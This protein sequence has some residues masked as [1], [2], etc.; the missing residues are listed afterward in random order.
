MIKNFIEPCL[1]IDF[2]AGDQGSNETKRFLKAT[3]AR[4]ERLSRL[5]DRPKET[6]HD[7]REDVVGGLCYI[8]WPDLILLCDGDGDGLFR[9]GGVLRIEA[10]P[11]G[12]IVITRHQSHGLRCLAMFR[13]MIPRRIV[14]GIAVIF[15]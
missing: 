13:H 3:A 15:E 10:L 6:R 1:A 8:Q 7:M 2:R 11:S 5:L 12:R 9:A 4:R 14:K